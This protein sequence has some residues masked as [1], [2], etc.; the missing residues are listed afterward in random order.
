PRR[1]VAY[2][3]SPMPSDV[4]MVLVHVPQAPWPAADEAL[5]A[6]KRPVFILDQRPKFRS[7]SGKTDGARIPTVPRVFNRLLALSGVAFGD[8]LA[9]F[10]ENAL[11]ISSDLTLHFFNE[12]GQRCLRVAGDR[13]VRLRHRL[14]I[15]NVALDEQI[16]RADADA[17]RILRR[18]ASALNLEIQNEIDCIALVSRTR[19]RVT[20]W[21]VH[22][23]AV[24]VNRTLQKLRKL[25]HQLHA[26]GR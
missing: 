13:E 21:N 19:Q 17:F 15:L 6:D 14:K 23:F 11:S 3:P 9:A 8:S 18:S 26:F 24:A 16:Q 10:F 1:L 22:A 5:P 2:P 20:R 25:C 12:R 4:V 7:Q